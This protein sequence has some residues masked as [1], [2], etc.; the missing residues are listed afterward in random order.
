M[1]VVVQISFTAGKHKSV[2]RYLNLVMGNVL[3]D[4]YTM[5]PTGGSTAKQQTLAIQGT[6]LVMGP[7]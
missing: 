5:T 7:A 4:G 6:Q 2:N 3:P 1:M